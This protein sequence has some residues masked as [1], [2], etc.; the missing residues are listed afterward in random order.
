M[1]HAGT[2]KFRFLKN[3]ARIPGSKLA[4][5]ARLFPSGVAF[6]RLHFWRFQDAL[7]HQRSP[8]ADCTEMRI[9]IAGATSGIGRFLAERLV[10]EGHDV[11]GFARSSDG[12]IAHARF[13]FVHGPLAIFRSGT[14]SISFV[15]GQDFPSETQQLDAII[16]CAA[17]QGPIGPAMTLLAKELEH[18]SSR[19]SSMGLSMLACV[20]FAALLRLPGK[21][22]G[23]KIRLLLSLDVRCNQAAREFF[24][25]YAA[26]KV[27]SS[28][29]FVETLAEGMARRHEIDI[30]S[31]APGA[32][33]TR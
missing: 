28:S 22:R 23:P 14:K 13:S 10:E 25:T 18:S 17:S 24:K 30:N 31:I 33:P 1:R 11:W 8:P 27:E 19:Q 9:L 3:L 7:C 21:V 20:P 2:I 26:L 6:R 32:L 29:K 15:P 16:I 12:A 4:P 5:L